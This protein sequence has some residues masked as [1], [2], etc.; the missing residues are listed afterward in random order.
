MKIYMFGGSFDPP[1][2]AHIEIVNRLIVDSDKLYI[3][4]A[5][6][7]PYKVN[8]AVS[9]SDQRFQMCR[10]AFQSIS[11][12]IE[13]SNFEFNSTSPSYTINTVRWIFNQFPEC[14]LSIIIGEDQGAQLST[15]H[16][17]EALQKLVSFICF[18]RKNF[19]LTSQVQ[20]AYIDGFDH[21]IS[22]TELRDTLKDDVKKV[23]PM[24]HPNVLAYIQENE[25]YSC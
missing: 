17:F 12:K 1:H 20:L 9:T 25:L 3:F 10:L 22:S 16:K 23:K 11:P 15:W 8:E 13:V 7:S 19:E 2:L 14:E 24:L 4:P 6:Q 5:K 21:E 18:S